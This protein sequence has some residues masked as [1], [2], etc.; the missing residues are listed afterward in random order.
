M[1]QDLEIPHIENSGSDGH[2]VSA[3][4]V[5]IVV[6]APFDEIP[7][8]KSITGL[9]AKGRGFGNDMA[10]SLV[11]GVTQHFALENRRLQGELDDC[12]TKLDVKAEILGKSQQDVAVLTQKLSAARKSKRIAQVVTFVGTVF[13]TLGLDLLLKNILIQAV[14]C[15]LLGAVLISVPWLLSSEDEA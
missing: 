4:V 10:N 8:A 14:V 9:A 5:A 6:E 13:F 1:N 15:F 3:P 7:L 12:R 11:V 2:Q